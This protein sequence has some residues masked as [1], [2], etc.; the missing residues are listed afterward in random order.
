MEA[1]L[2]LIQYLREHMVPLMRAE[3]PH[4]L[5][6]AHETENMALNAEM[7]LRASLFRKESRGWHYRE[8]YPEQND[9]E[10]LA[11]N[12]IRLGTDGG[13]ELSRVEIP[14]EWRPVGGPA[15]KRPWLAWEHPE[16]ERS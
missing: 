8:D 13:M 6:L 12:Q 1:T 10:W 7:I 9:R 2:T 3:D 4:M 14:Q 16:N 5:R 11:W 15:G